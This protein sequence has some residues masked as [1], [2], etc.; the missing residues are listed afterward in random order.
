[1]P[2]AWRVPNSRGAPQPLP[3]PPALDG[4][5]DGGGSTRRARA[6]RKSIGNHAAEATPKASSPRWVPQCTHGS[7]RQGYEEAATP[8][9][10]PERMALSTRVHRAV[11]T[12][13]TASTDASS[14]AGWLLERPYTCSLSP[15]KPSRLPPATA[16]TVAY[17]A[18]GHPH[19]VRGRRCEYSS[20]GSGAGH[21]GTR[22]YPPITPRAAT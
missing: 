3:R 5:G 15:A 17:R 11:T 13:T 1:M 6:A 9:R 4:S 20:R 12:A 21:A 10:M 19:T 7:S 18:Y 16:T 2:P 22:T 8:A 14:V